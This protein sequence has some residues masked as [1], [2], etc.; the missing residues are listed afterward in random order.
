ML[1][2]SICDAL[3]LSAKESQRKKVY[4]DIKKKVFCFL[5]QTKA[6]TSLNVLN[7]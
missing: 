3:A 4:G 2:L 7:I 1:D 5:K 6:V